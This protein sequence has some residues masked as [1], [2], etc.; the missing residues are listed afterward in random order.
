MLDIFFDLSTCVLIDVYILL[1]VGA[2]PKYNGFF[3]VGGVESKITKW[4]LLDLK[5]GVRGHVL[6]RLL[7][8]VSNWKS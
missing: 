1:G 8:A 4:L 6:K 5:L 7:T 3:G 2:F